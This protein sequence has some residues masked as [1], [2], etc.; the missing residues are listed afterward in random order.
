MAG[1]YER[2]RASGPNQ[3]DRSGVLG[4]TG[5]VPVPGAVDRELCDRAVD[6]VG[7]HQLAAVPGVAIRLPGLLDLDDETRRR[8]VHARPLNPAR[9]RMPALAQRDGGRDTLRLESPG[10]SGE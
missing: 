4:H 7:A 5:G 8:P 1:S 9:P 6:D 2:A 3:G 10:R